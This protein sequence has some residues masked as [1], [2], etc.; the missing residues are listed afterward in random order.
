MESQAQTV[1]RPRSH[2]YQ[3]SLV[4][5][6]LRLRDSDLIGAE[7]LPRI[8]HHPDMSWRRTS[9]QTTARALQAS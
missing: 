9:R 7:G 3:S 8:P 5:A 4:C 1:C 2:G 6:N